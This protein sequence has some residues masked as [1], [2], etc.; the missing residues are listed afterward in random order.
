MARKRLLRRKV[1]TIGHRTRPIPDYHPWYRSPHGTT[2]LCGT[3]V[4]S[5][6][7]TRLAFK[8][9]VARSSRARLISQ[10][11]VVLRTFRPSPLVVPAAAAKGIHPFRRI[12]QIAWPAPTEARVLPSPMYCQRRVYNPQ[13]R[14]DRIPHVG[15]V[16]TRRHNGLVSPSAEGSHPC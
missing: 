6:L 8:Q 2:T 10:P 11:V 3:S 14:S 7:L 15:Q 12:S 1:L 16:A 4:Y 5:P 9:V 13:K